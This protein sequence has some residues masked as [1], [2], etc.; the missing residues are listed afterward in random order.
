MC[1][2]EKLMNTVNRGTGTCR[3]FV[4][5]GF[6]VWIYDQCL[7]QIVSTSSRP[8]TSGI[9]VCTLHMPRAR[10]T[11][12]KIWERMQASIA[13]ASRVQNL[14]SKNYTEMYYTANS[15]SIICC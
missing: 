7:S 3:F 12:V 2:L 9:S 15:T 1:D 6:G 10:M 13:R 5:W 11:R 4:F 14:G 8:A